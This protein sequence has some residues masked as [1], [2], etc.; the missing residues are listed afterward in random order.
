MKKIFLL[1]LSLVLLIL[2]N[3]GYAQEDT[4]FGISSEV[5]VGSNYLLRVQ[6]DEL[7]L[8]GQFGFNISSNDNLTINN[9]RI[10]GGAL[11]DIYSGDKIDTFTGGKL[12]IGIETVDLNN[13]SDSETKVNITP[14]LGAR[15]RIHP[16][17]S[18]SY[19]LQLDLSF[20]SFYATTKGVAY[21]TLWLQ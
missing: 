11:F 15:Y 4:K 8:I 5:P 7:Q 13:N 12:V 20:G 3:G 19:E 2:I 1:T 16:A 21:L 17:L 9:W 10:G 6:M 14:I 18:L